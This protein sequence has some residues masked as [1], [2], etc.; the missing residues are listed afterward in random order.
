MNESKAAGV[1]KKLVSIM[2]SNHRM[3]AEKLGTIELYPGQPPLL[4]KLKKHGGCSQKELSEDALVKPATITVMLSRMEKAGLVKRR[5][6]SRDSRV[7]RTYLTEKGKLR[8]DQAKD[9]MYRQA[10]DMLAPLTIEE[11]EIFDRLLTKILNGIL[12]AENDK[13][14]DKPDT[15]SKNDTGGTD[16]I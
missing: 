12:A 14:K 11:L 13:L 3:L 1:M 15:K 8:S 6:D 9:M 7:S 5:V 10:E 2:K 4:I 16:I